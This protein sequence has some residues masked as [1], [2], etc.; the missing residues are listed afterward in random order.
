[1][2][3]EEDVIEGDATEN[4]EDVPTKTDDPAP[5]DDETPDGPTD[6]PLPGDNETDDEPGGDDDVDDS[7][8]VKVEPT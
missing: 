2:T 6:I 5:T 1:M 3:T 7:E 8:P 4:G